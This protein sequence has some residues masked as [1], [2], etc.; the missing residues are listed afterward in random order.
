M[1]KEKKL[2]AKL[3]TRNWL[4]VIIL[5]L[6][7]QI[8]WGIENSWFNTFI[9]DEIT[10]DPQAIAIMVGVSAIVATVGTLIMGTLS[11]RI[12][13]R[14]IFMILGYVFWGLSTVAF[15]M[16]AMAKTV[17]I[18]VF[19]VI[20]L[21]A[22]MT[23]FGSTA[24]DAAYNAWVTDNTDETNRGFV[25]G[26]VLILPVFAGLLLAASGAII[27]NFGYNIF[28]YSV[29]AVVTI[30]GLIIG[31]L[32]KES[33]TLKPNKDSKE[34]NFFKYMVSVFSIKSIK[35]NKLLFQVFVV[36]CV[37]NI[38]YQ[39]TMAYD[40][41]YINNYLGISK[42][43]ASLLGLFAMPV[44]LVASIILGK[45]NDKGKGYQLITI[46]PLLITIG[47][48]LFSFSTEFWQIV[49]TKSIFFIGFFGLMVSAQAQI[50]NLMPENQRGQFQG[51]NM[52]FMVL[53]P[54]VIGPAIGSFLIKTFGTP[55]ILNGSA[56]FV[57]TPII[58]QAAGVV[59][60]L[61]Y[62]GIYFMRKTLKA[63]KDND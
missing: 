8:A 17:S 40:M 30:S 15:P 41:I 52:V 35:A 25:T 39:V 21:D 1:E 31:L 44:I 50:K 20:T 54:M 37:A 18:A 63:N 49:V 55:T 43:L 10:P 6:A 62:I 26:I 27:D 59:S 58:Y 61:A 5:G 46:S 12:G 23:F 53:L 16:S 48:V 38:A 9:F 47:M 19:L 56:G 11:D 51:A 14:K 22:V 24:Y 60:L 42:T 7:G 2:S 34:K 29:G 32:I 45:L 4:V 36:M 57:P 3:G 28:F 33:P 13:K